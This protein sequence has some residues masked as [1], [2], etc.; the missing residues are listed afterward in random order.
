MTS[1]WLVGWN[2]KKDGSPLPHEVDVAIIGGGATGL[3]EA[4]YRLGAW[5]HTAK[6]L[7]AIISSEPLD[8]EGLLP[9]VTKWLDGHIMPL[10]NQSTATGRRL[11]MNL[12]VML[13]KKMPALSSRVAPELWE[14]IKAEKELTAA[15]TT[16]V[17]AI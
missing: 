14:D 7:D 2:P 13:S 1:P 9:N 6:H 8:W 12:A 4:D 5:A 16:G 10:L 15:D 17:L 3:C 11:Q